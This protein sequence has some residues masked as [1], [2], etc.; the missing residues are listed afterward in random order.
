MPP[1][2]HRPRPP[3]YVDHQLADFASTAGTRSNHLGHW[4]DPDHVDPGVDVRIAQE[5]LDEIVLDLADVRDAHRVLDVG[6]GFGGTMLALDRRL[7]GAELLGLDV[8]HRQLVTDRCLSPCRT[9]QF[10]WLCGD[11]SHLP[12]RSASV[13][14]IV[15]IEALW[16]LPSREQFLQAAARVLVPGGRVVVVDILVQPGAGPVVGV[17]DRTV[18]AE[19]SSTF[20]PWPEVFGSVAQL[21]RRAVDAGLRPLRHVDATRQTAPTYLDHGDGHRRPGDA[22]FANSSGVRM[23]VALHLAG[24]LQVVYASFERPCA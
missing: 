5:R 6:C 7:Q 20:D 12:V 19:L 15:S 9:N 4:D 3:S 18:E 22:G 13:D 2:H 17:D 10:L 24:A 11:G 1:P 23:F 8:D 16:H 21:E 14:R